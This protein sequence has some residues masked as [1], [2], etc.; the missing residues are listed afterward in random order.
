MDASGTGRLPVED[1][2]L[3]FGY[4]SIDV[5]DEELATLQALALSDRVNEVNLHTLLKGL[6]VH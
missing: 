4:A 3:A 1:V 5:S 6:Q 2:R